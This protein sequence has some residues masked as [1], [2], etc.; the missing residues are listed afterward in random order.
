MLLDLR[1]GGSMDKSF[2]PLFDEIAG[3]SRNQFNEIITSSSSSLTQNLDWWSEN[4]SSRNTYSCPLFH[5]ICCLNLFRELLKDNSPNISEIYVDSKQLQ[6][7]LEKIKKNSTFCKVKISYKKPFIQRLKNSLSPLYYEFFFLIRVLRLCLVKILSNSDNNLFNSPIVLID[8]FITKNYVEEDRWYGCLWESLSE[9]QKS[10]IYFV[11]S[12]VDSSFYSFC[13]ILIRLRTSK[14]NVILK[15]NFLNI[16]DIL[17]AY[18]HKFRLKRISI[19]NSEI[20]GLDL[21]DLVAECLVSN[22][23]VHSTMESLIT[24][25]FLRNLSSKKIKVR[26]SIDWFEGHC[27]DKLWNLGMYKFF[28]YTKRFAYET[29]RSFPYYLS[30]Y[31]IPIEK[32]A[33]VIPETFLVQGP[34]CVDALKEFI[35]ELNVI[36]VP[37]LKN[38]H[39]WNSDNLQYISKNT[40]LVAFPISIDTSVKML[41]TLIQYSMTEESKEI[42]YILKPHPI[43]SPSD[44]E[45]KL[46]SHLPSS[47]NFS[48]EKS[49]PDLLK[50]CSILI[51]EASS[52]CLEALAVGKPV[53]IINNSSGLTYDPVPR[54]VPREL[55]RKCSSHEDINSSLNYFLNLSNDDKLKIIDLSKRIRSDY[56]EPLT[57]EGLN[58]FLDI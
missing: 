25:N 55:F 36:S 41:E 31:P 39:V 33:K 27:V 18:L 5:Y 58:R 16:K 26:L 54:D 12:F 28:P 57:K 13:E 4:V 8:T 17:D 48:N 44:I 30:T 14:R 52:V 50:A 7:I 53:I 2:A 29:F 45:S 10:E 19:C 56:F 22:R 6:L 51:T 9:D 35:P 42:S 3:R 38:Q 37:A 40:V 24:Y 32:E 23:D 49:F 34:A 11:P 15:E 47:F 1:F 43:N 20:D 46:Q 21:T